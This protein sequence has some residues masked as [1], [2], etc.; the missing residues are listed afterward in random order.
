M[1]I[2]N[3]WRNSDMFCHN[4]GSKI[5]EGAA[6][7]HNCGTKV[8]YV[9]REQQ[10]QFTSKIIEETHI[11]EEAVSAQP[12]LDVDKTTV[13]RG[14]KCY[15][16]TIKPYYREQFDR[17]EAGQK[18]KFNWAA[19]FFNGW[20]QLYNGCTRIFFKTFL[21]MLIIGF[22]ISLIIIWNNLRGNFIFVS[23]ALEIIWGIC[24]F[25]LCILNGFKFNMWY[26][27]DV[28]KN[29][30]KKR[31]KK[32]MGIL[33]VSEIAVCAVIYMLSSILKP[34]YEDF[35]SNDFFKTQTEDIEFVESYT[36]EEERNSFQHSDNRKNIDNREE[37]FNDTID[38]K[39]IETAKQLILEWFERH[40][41]KQDIR[42]RF[43]NERMD[44]ESGISNYLKYELYVIQG[45]YGVLCVNPTTGDMI[46]D[47]ITDDFGNR[48]SVQIPLEQ[49]YLEYYWGWTDKSK[50]ETKQIYDN[51]YVICDETGAALFEFHSSDDSYVICDWDI[52]CFVEYDDGSTEYGSERRIGDII[53]TY[54]CDESFEVNGQFVNFYYS[55]EI[56]WDNPCFVITETWRGNTILQDWVRP[57]SLTGNTLIFDM[58]NESGTGY[59]ESSLLY[60]PAKDSPLGQDTIYLDGDETM[61]FVREESNTQL[62]EKIDSNEGW[63]EETE[64]GTDVRM[65]EGTYLKTIGPKCELS[66]R[67]VNERGVSFSVK[68]GGSGNLAYV[69]MRNCQAQWIDHNTAAYEENGYQI[70]IT[71]EDTQ[72]FLRVSENRPSP[73]FEDFS[74][75]GIYIIESMAEENCEF[76]FPEDNVYTITEEDLEGKTAMECKI[77]RNEIYA[78][79]G[80]IFKDEQLQGYFNTCDWYNGTIAS[81]Q[82]SENMLNEIE[83]ANIQTIINYEKKRG[84]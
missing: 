62:T 79:Y 27:Q 43:T 66:I 28:I 1:K 19:F 32:G 53:G 31:S 17:I 16:D 63:T 60:L 70:K 71:V 26:Y 13:Y 76:V 48:K 35:V 84:Y 40:P 42:V 57:N 5:T 41:L 80:R 37:S 58:M 29:P 2:L 9:N 18:T 22:T 7:C 47:S 81:E 51:L 14:E 21:P 82:F 34:S 25:V 69:D 56:A 8:L 83:K 77:A 72:G 73:Y 74:L 50:Y 24:S 20:N 59:K 38:L 36:N 54:S 10:A 15:R 78:R 75:S 45:E 49:W 67:E 6:F 61:P 44:A 12:D 52:L 30:N 39:D 11:T 33:I 55:L 64:L 4:C 65:V 68:I 3:K 46:M 23:L